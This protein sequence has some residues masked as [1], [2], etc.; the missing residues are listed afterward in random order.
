[1]K[2]PQT[3]RLKCGVVSINPEVEIFK[4]TEHRQVGYNRHGDGQPLSRR[5][6]L[7]TI[8]RPDWLV[9]DSPD[10]PRV[11]RDDQAHE[12]VDRGRREHQQRESR[13]GPSVKR[14]TGKDQPQIAPTLRRPG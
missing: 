6:W 9:R 12:P 5:F 14:V 8:Q 11:V 4:E 10:L 13:L 2:V 1:M 7:S 3:Q